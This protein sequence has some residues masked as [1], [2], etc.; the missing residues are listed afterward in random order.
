[1]RP[2]EPDG[3]EREAVRMTSAMPDLAHGA[4]RV[5]PHPAWDRSWRRV[6]FNGVDGDTRRVYLADF[7]RLVC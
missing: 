5:D 1:M 6:V 3:S 7:S 2:L 4:L